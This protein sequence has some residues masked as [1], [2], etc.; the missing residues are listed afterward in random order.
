MKYKHDKYITY[1]YQIDDVV[2]FKRLIN[3]Y[4]FRITINEKG[5]FINLFVRC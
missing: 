3:N 1:K 2:L 5:E 4:E